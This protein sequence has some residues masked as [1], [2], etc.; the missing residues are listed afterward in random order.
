[1]VYDIHNV[2]NSY[3][4]V[5]LCVPAVSCRVY[6]SEYAYHDDSV[7][8]AE[9]V[10]ANCRRYPPRVDDRNI[11][12]THCNSQQLKL[13]DSDRGSNTEYTAT[14]YYEWTAGRGDQL[15][16]TTTVIVSETVPH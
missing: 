12:Y 13:S 3:Y 4:F 1:M 10:S 16:C 15:L 5:V 14:S 8:R 11:V 9:S 2:I 6:P 7:T